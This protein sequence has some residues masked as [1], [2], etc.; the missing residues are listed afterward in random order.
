MLPRLLPHRACLPGGPSIYLPAGQV[1]LAAGAVA[2]K[3]AGSYFGGVDAAGPSSRARRGA[4]NQRHC[5]RA[6]HAASS[7]GESTPMQARVPLTPALPPVPSPRLPACRRAGQNGA[8]PGA[9]AVHSYGLAQLPGLRGCSSAADPPV[10]RCAA[11]AGGAVG[12]AGAAA[13]GRG[14]WRPGAGCSRGA[15]EYCQDPDILP[16]PLCLPFARKP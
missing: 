9:A 11:G 3:A 13:G 1:L 14:L 12:T 2:A 8:E 5:R 7:R 4:G 10:N 6:S 15:R 16:A